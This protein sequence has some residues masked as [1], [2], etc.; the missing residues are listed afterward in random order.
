[1]GL[2]KKD[3]ANDEQIFIEEVFLL[4]RPF[5]QEVFEGMKKDGL[6]LENTEAFTQ[7]LLL[8]FYTMTKSESSIAKYMFPIMMYLRNIRKKRL[9]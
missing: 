1:M 9:G 7:R 8:R 3:E 2:F 6:S 4:T 5:I